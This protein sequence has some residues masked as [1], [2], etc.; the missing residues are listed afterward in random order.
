MQACLDRC[1]S[2]ILEI[3]MIGS[4]WVGRWG[5]SSKVGFDHVGDDGARL[6]E[7]EGGDGRMHLVKTLAAAQQFGID[8]AD[9]VELASGRSRARV[10][11]AASISRFVLALRTWIC[12]PMVRAASCTSRN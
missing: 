3:I 11:K 10:A 9:L 6:G 5:A 2:A 1:R 8:R 7:V 4:L 12:S